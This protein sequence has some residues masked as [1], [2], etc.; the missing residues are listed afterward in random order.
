MNKRNRIFKPIF[1]LF[2]LVLA[3][4]S[5]LIAQTDPAAR[6]PVPTPKQLW[7]RF[8]K[9]LDPLEYTISKRKSVMKNRT[10]I[11]KPAFWP[12]NSLTAPV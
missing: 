4:E 6:P 7:E 8:Q 1:Y 10:F 3:A 9:T 12:R 5:G 2:M 11:Q